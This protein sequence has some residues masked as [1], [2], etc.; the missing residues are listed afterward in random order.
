MRFAT[1]D[2]AAPAASAS[3]EPGAALVQVALPDAL[4]E[5]AVL[6]KRAFEAKCISC[7]GEN[8]AGVDGAGPPLV[9]KIYEP[10]HHGD[11]AFWLAT[12]NGVR[13]HHWTFGSMPPVDGLTKGDVDAILTYVRAL[14]AANGIL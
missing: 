6:G 14:Q 1:D 3:G 13:A 12:Q 8:A 2:D 7:H 10:S 4:S 5:R 9:H 11:A